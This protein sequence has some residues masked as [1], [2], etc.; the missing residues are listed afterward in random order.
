MRIFRHF[1]CVTIF[2]I[3]LFST[4]FATYLH[5]ADVNEIMDQLFVYHIDQKRMNS[6]IMTRALKIYM[7]N[8]DSEYAYLSL[9][10]IEKFLSPTE[11]NV[12][13]FIS[14]YKQ[15]E[16][17]CFF[18]I[19]QLC[20]AS[21][22]RARMWRK[23]WSQHSEDLLRD[24]TLVTELKLHNENFAPN[25][26][27]LKER[28]RNLFV[29]LIALHM[30][31]LDETSYKGREQRLITLAEKQMRLMENGYLGVDEQ[32]VS[33]GQE[34]QESQI[35]LKVAKAMASSLD[36]HTA[37][38]SSSEALS[39]R[40][41]LAKEM[42]GIGVV[43]QEGID[44]IMIAEL[45]KGG[46]AER[47][48]A[49]QVGDTI[50]MVDNT[51][52]SEQS[53][54]RVLEL[55]RGREGTKLKLKMARKNDLFDVEVKRAQIVLDDKRVDVSSEPYG[56]GIIGKI[57]LHSFYEGAEGIT[58]ELDLK[59]AITQ[60]KKEGPLYGLVLDLRENSGGFLSQ[61]V[62][63]SGLFIKSGV[64][65]ISKY[66]DGSLKYHR[67]FNRT[68][69]YDGPLVVLISRGS[70]S[71]AE[72]VAQALQDY[73]VAIVVGDE[74][75]Y[76]KGTIQHQ[77][78]TDENAKSFFKVTIGRYYTVSGKSTQIDG[79]KSDIFVP[80]K[81]NFEKLGEGFAE[82]PLAAD[83]V[84][85]AYSDNL[86]DVDPQIKKWFKNHYA[87]GM[88]NRSE[89]WADSIVLLKENSNKRLSSDENFQLFL[90]SVQQG[91]EE[92]AYGKRDLQMVESV[93][94]LKDMI[95]LSR[96]E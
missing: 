3:S 93:N 11:E 72:I 68:K 40:T 67:N 19:N 37:V 63:V 59:A 33:L 57:T 38:F 90:K 60:L 51:D 47:C 70:A 45:I 88:Q 29:H 86:S 48:G 1:T 56:D 53:F 27:T 16:Y 89:K 78:V 83:R 14:D 52:V 62:K 35:F 91:G 94:I 87:S 24:A 26:E 5:S 82:Y 15:K 31:K 81:W 9:S 74:Q 32:G 76:G 21:A 36:V 61:A 79:V 42:C 69:F 20:K 28:H 95:F 84:A 6:Q 54:P 23:Q 75:S 43:L 71:A 25:L 49:L 96:I 41:Q 55:M 66:S 85:D 77:T 50:V 10:E 8:F 4:L 13:Q 18:Q 39:M 17:R 58:S 65:V 2:L 22:E 44:G 30:K 73:G 64:V 46:P 12:K 80:T 34:E 92:E 7:Q